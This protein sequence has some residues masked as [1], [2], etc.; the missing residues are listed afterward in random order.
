M[1]SPTEVANLARQ[2]ADIVEFAADHIPLRRRG[3]T[4]L[5]QGRCPFHAG[6]GED[7]VV[8][9]ERRFYYCYACRDAGDVLRLAERLLGLPPEAAARALAERFGVE[10]PEELAPEVLAERRRAR[11]LEARIRAACEAAAA[12]FE[13]R[14]KADGPGPEVARRSTSARATSGCRPPTPKPPAC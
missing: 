5:W 4:D 6:R 3:A 8:S 1:P 14:L 11:D 2:A 9:A 10:V 13:G 12:F 7:F